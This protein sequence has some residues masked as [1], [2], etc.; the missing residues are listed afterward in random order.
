MNRMPIALAGGVLIFAGIGTASAQTVI[1]DQGFAPP[2][3]AVAPAP[4]YT[5]APAPAY[6]VPV[7]PG[8]VYVAPAPVYV[9]P[10]VPVRPWH[11]QVVI[12]ARP[13]WDAAPGVVYSD[14]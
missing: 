1:V 13:V 6:T 7:V 5:V 2:A 10:G 12:D 9:A 14:W 4:A 3:Y 8:P 11:R